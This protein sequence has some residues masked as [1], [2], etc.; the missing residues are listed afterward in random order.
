[1]KT[2]SREVLSRIRSQ[3]KLRRLEIQAKLNFIKEKTSLFL[4]ARAKK[5]RGQ[6]K[7]PRDTEI[8]QMELHEVYIRYLGS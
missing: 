2:P 8:E 4:E 7:I 5:R 6:I 3:R 1:M